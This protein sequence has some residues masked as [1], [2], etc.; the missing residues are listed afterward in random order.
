ML[1]HLVEFLTFPDAEF[2]IYPP[3]NL[4]AP[5]LQHVSKDR[6]LTENLLWQCHAERPCLLGRQ[7]SWTQAQWAF[8]I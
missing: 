4:I 5:G 8:R 7:G 6:P 3:L 1:E 2:H